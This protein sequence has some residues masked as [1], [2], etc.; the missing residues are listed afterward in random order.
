MPYKA[1][2]LV[3]LRETRDAL[4]RR[5][6]T[7]TLHR[8]DQEHPTT[9]RLELS[10]TS[11]HAMISIEFRHA[12]QGDGRAF[13]II[14]HCASTDPGYP[15]DLRE[16]HRELE[17]PDTTPMVTWTNE[18][19]GLVEWNPRLGPARVELSACGATEEP[20][21]VHLGLDFAGMGFYLLRVDVNSIRPTSSAEQSR[22]EDPQRTGAAQKGKGG[23]AR[24]FRKPVWSWL[25]LKSQP[26]DGLAT[27]RLKEGNGLRGT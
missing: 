26:R 7:A 13:T 11:R 15:E 4:A 24:V 16:G 5:G 1:L 14:A 22:G 25:R 3:L 2:T 6:Y 18:S 27:E 12:L 17:A 20:V 23:W 9:H 10:S 21:V 8:P 19:S